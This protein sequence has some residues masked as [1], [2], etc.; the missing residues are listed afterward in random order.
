M[1]D[2]TMYAAKD[3]RYLE[4]CN[5]AWLMSAQKISVLIVDDSA[6]VRQTLREVLE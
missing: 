3:R 5:E 6:V 1:H 4:G 2:V